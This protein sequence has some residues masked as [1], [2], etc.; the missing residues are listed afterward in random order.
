MSDYDTTKIENFEELLKKY[1]D[2][3]NERFSEEDD[4]LID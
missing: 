3:I 2:A 4:P 1:I